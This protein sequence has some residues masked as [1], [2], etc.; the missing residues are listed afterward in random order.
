MSKLINGRIPVGSD[1]PFATECAIKEEGD[2]KHK[3]VRHPVDFSC[4]T[5]RGF[6]MAEAGPRLPIHK[7]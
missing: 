4:A 5:A 7:D 3:G 2:C 6:D 1:C